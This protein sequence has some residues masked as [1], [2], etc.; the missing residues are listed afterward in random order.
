MAVT[1][2]W[3]RTAATRQ[4]PFRVLMVCTGNICRSPAAERLLAA[5]LGPDAD[6]VVTSAGTHAMVGHPVSAPMVPLLSAAGATAKGF[7]AR[8]VTEQMLREADLVL[9]LTRHHR[10]HLVRKE[11]STVRRTFTLRELARLAEEVDPAA[12]VATTPG[13]RLAELVPLAAARRGRTVVDP[14]Q[15]DVEDPYGHS[16]EHYARSF[17]QLRPAVETLVRLAGA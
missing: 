9:A 15:D 3:A 7:A 2:S 8:Q 1:T 17:G 12:L 16:P 14:E 13:T 4:G 10:A 6:V 11:P 5:A